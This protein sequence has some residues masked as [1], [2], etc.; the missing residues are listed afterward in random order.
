[1]DQQG[2]ARPARIRSAL[3]GLLGFGAGVALAALVAL[4]L[5]WAFFWRSGRRLLAGDRLLLI[6]YGE[7]TAGADLAH[8]DAESLQVRGGVV[9]L[10]IPPPEIFSTRIRAYAR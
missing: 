6:V 9:E 4:L 3:T 10:V 5:A 1:M 2:T 8:L 7:V